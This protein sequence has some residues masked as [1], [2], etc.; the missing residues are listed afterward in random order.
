MDVESVWNSSFYTDDE[1]QQLCRSFGIRGVKKLSREA[2][3]EKLKHVFHTTPQGQYFLSELAKHVRRAEKKKKL[4]HGTCEI[5][6]TRG[7]CE[8]ES[9][10]KPRDDESEDESE[11]DDVI[12]DSEE[13]E[14]DA[15]SV[16]SESESED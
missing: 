6:K 4:P 7:T 2:M 9:K 8:T 16:H 10:K 15:S 11:S 5:C 12:E 3:N 14:T 13:T 1:L